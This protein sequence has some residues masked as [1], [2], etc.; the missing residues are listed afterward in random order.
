MSI[1]G[2]AEAKAGSEQEWGEL[3]QSR[4]M[5]V[6]YCQEHMSRVLRQGLVTE[7]TN[8]EGDLEEL[9]KQRGQ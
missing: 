8:S 4:Q 5:A 9:V 2:R 1:L 7:V 6:R 3:A